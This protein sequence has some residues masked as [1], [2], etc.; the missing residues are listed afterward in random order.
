MSY[1]S[2]R[3]SDLDALW[4]AETELW[5]ALR[6]TDLGRVI[7]GGWSVGETPAHLADYHQFVAGAVAAGCSAD[8][9]PESLTTSAALE[10]WDRAQRAAA[11]LRG[12]PISSMRAFQDSQAALRD[13]IQDLDGS[14]YLPWLAVRGCRSLAFALEYLFY[15]NWAH[16]AQAHLIIQDWLPGLPERITHNALHFHMRLLACALGAWPQSVAPPAWALTIDGLA[17]GAWR[18]ERTETGWRVE[19]VQPADV[20][21]GDLLIRA[22]SSAETFVRKQWFAAGGSGPFGARR[23]DP[24]Y[25]WVR[26]P[27][28]AEWP[29][30]PEKPPG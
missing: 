9:P 17:G 3:P 25:Q 29:K 4:E 12:P 18:F 26:P 15:H 5:S 28:D 8:Q 14:V 16:F 30:I 27:D 1:E 2:F 13:A 19:R 24:I 21:D 11:T 23:P 7:E 10:A 6:P 20:H 22:Y